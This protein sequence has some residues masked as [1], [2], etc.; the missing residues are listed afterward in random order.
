[1]TPPY[2]RF[3]PAIWRPEMVIAGGVVYEMTAL[4]LAAHIERCSRV[5]VE[6]LCDHRAPVSP[7]KASRPTH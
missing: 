7:D 3:N 6:T 5:L 2:V 1:M 4:E